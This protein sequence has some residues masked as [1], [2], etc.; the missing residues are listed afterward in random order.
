M[1]QLNPSKLKKISKIIADRASQE[2]AEI[3]TLSGRYRT[4]DQRAVAKLFEKHIDGVASLKREFDALMARNEAKAE[5]EIKKLRAQAL[6]NARSRKPAL[7]R[8]IAQR[9]KSFETLADPV[10]V[11][12]AKRHFVNTPIEIY[13]TVIG[14]GSYANEPSNSWAKFLLDYAK[15]H[16]LWPAVGAWPSVVFCFVWENPTDKYVVI[17]VLAYMSLHG[18]CKLSSPGGFFPG[19]RRSELRMWPKL[20]LFDYTTEPF[21]S[22]LGTGYELPDPV[23]VSTDTGGLSDDGYSETEDVFRAD[24]LQV[25]LVLVPPSTAVGLHASVDIGIKTGDDGG[26]VYADFISHSYGMIVPGI[27]ITVVS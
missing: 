12:S 18:Y 3:R 25:Y 15:G 20:E 27:L 11:P 26:T 22:L 1:A 7:D 19:D 2:D 6:K 17:N 4:S 23:I 5:S 14:L 24:G 10:N 21:P 13:S 16:E 9:V 8:M